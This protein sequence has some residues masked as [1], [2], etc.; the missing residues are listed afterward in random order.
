M[1]FGAENIQPVKYTSTGT[2]VTSHNVFSVDVYTH[3]DI[4]RLTARIACNCSHLHVNT[5]IA[6]VVLLYR[7]IHLFI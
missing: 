2:V 1:R 7:V 6:I 4:S 3:S 5:L